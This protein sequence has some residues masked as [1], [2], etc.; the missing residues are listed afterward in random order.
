VA[1]GLNLITAQDVDAA[2]KEFGR[3]GREGFLEKYGFG[4]AL[5]YF[6]LDPATRQWAD[7]K[8]V[9][10]AAYGFR[11]P[12]RGPLKS[13]DFSGG[14][15]QVVRLLHALG[16]RVATTA[17][18]EA[19]SDD[20]TWSKAEVVLLVADYLEMLSLELAG[21]GFNKAARRRALL[22][23]LNGRSEASIEFKR[24]N[25]SA[26]LLEFG[27]PTLRGYLPAENWQSLLMQVVADQVS[28]AGR[29][30]ELSQSFVDTLAVPAEV[31]SFAK[32]RVEAPVR[33]ERR[34][35]E[36]LPVVP[37][38]V[39][40][41][42]VE[43]E[44]RNRSLGNAGELFVVQYEQWRLASA[45]L[46]QL[47]EKVCHVSVED[48]DG[49][50]YDVRTYEADGGERYIE[51]KTTALSEFTPFFVSS[52]ELNFARNCSAQYS[53]YRLFNFRT[54]PQ[55]FELRGAIETHCKLDPATFRALLH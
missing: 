16:Y 24:R 11:F 4:R 46:G 54:V 29:L 39:K 17:E 52:N 10:G 30:N 21:Q 43:Q 19:E 3:R 28:E 42:F 8:A 25:V 5:D 22:P 35:S 53:L 37:R 55:F 44:A 36:P 1:S 26:V 9:I 45:G 51:V 13:N 15:V 2:L 33:R 38:V 32:S 49:L 50:G 27:Y 47:A 18:L 7:S 48:G 6:V 23:L 41:D 40:R 34:V 12:S 31:A 14:Q 20:R